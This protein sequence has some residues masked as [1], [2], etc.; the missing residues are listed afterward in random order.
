MTLFINNTPVIDNQGQLVLGQYATKANL[1]QNGVTGYLVYLTDQK[2]LLINTAQQNY[3]STSNTPPAPS[4][5]TSTPDDGVTWYKVL[6]NPVSNA[7]SNVLTQGT[8]AGG[9]NS[10]SVW[11]EITNIKFSTDS[12]TLMSQTLPWATKYSSA[13]SSLTYA[14]YHTGWTNQANTVAPSQTA[15]Q[16]WTTQA[17]SLITSTRPQVTGA[18]ATTF[19]S[20]SALDVAN[21]NI[22][23]IQYAA[24]A[25]VLDFTTDTW[26]ADNRYC[27][28]LHE[29]YGWSA[30]GSAFS[31]A[32]TRNV[33]KFNWPT[34]TWS[35]TGQAAPQTA[36]AETGSRGGMSTN[37][38]NKS[39]NGYYQ[40]LD[41]WNEASE[42]W[43]TVVTSGTVDGPMSMVEMSAI[44]GQN[45]GYWFGIPYLSDG[46]TPGY[47][48]DSRKTVYATDTTYTNPQ[49]AAG[50][51]GWGAGSPPP[52]GN[53]AC[54]C[55]GP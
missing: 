7:L 35:S 37:G 18:Q 55:S 39:Y 30:S 49:T 12:S 47:R 29:N 28:P 34:K 23:A 50:A 8:L 10:T 52:T 31:Y 32:T 24:V 27:P 26:T 51:G 11:N 54:T 1:P 53:S 22:G 21:Q 44:T 33:Q 4:T 2:E 19:Q 42:V 6:A 16:S 9:Y 25:D 14:Y 43:S 3:P 45:W 46:T 48:A 36:V 20:G 38:W 17:I 5:L 40:W 15:K 41:K 13:N